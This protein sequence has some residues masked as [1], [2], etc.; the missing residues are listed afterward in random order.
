MDKSKKNDRPYQ[1]DDAEVFPVDIFPEDVFPKDAFPT[2][3]FPRKEQK[4]PPPKKY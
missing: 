2:D 1:Q 4:Q 3:I